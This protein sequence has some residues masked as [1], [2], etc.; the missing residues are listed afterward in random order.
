MRQEIVI[1]N[2]SC[3]KTLKLLEPIVMFL[4]YCLYNLN[5]QPISIFDAKIC[6][7]HLNECL[8][9]CLNCYEELD[10]MEENSNYRLHNRIVIE[11]I[12]LM[13][14]M[15]DC[16]ALTRAIKLNSDLK[17]AFVMQIAIRISI[18]FHQRNFYKLLNDIQEL[19]HLVG[20]IASLKLS[21]IRKEIFRIFSIAY[22]N[23]TLKVPLEFLQRLL[24]YDEKALLLKNL[25]DLGIHDG[26]KNHIDEIVFNRKKF[27]SAKSI[28]SIYKAFS[29]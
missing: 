25:H 16:G 14:N 29:C 13:I 2:F 9:K 28:V 26:D 18:S 6:R 4:S 12:Y 3:E 24:I 11:S 17:S 7:Q 21:D 1:Q 23:Q 19:P 22:S 10:E 27:D 15:D 20:A 5:A 8:L